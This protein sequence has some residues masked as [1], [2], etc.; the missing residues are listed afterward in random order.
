MFCDAAVAPLE[1]VFWLAAGGW[2]QKQA[3]VA[4]PE[5][6]A[7]IAFIFRILECGPSGRRTNRV[8]PCPGAGQQLAP[9]DVQIVRE[10][11]IADIALVTR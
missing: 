3:K 4:A 11:A 6:T 2:R 8:P 1:G 9:D 10:H 5:D 7:P